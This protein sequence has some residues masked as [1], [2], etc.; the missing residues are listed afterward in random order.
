MPVQQARDKEWIK[1]GVIYF[2]AS[3][4][5]LSVEKNFSFSL[6]VE[7]PQSFAR[8]S[9]DV[10]MQSAADAYGNKL[11]GVLLT[12]ANHDGAA[13]LACIKK[14]GGLCVVQ[15]PQEAEVATMPQAAINLFK[16]DVVLKL[17]EIH[18]LL[19]SIG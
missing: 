16:P 19:R 1:P 2:A 9:I 6:S 17:N 4:Y 7:D 12:G 13:G 18:Q 3:G 5:H 8:P 10:L 14:A 15:D 11:A